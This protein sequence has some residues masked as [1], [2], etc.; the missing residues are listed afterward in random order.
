V[1]KRRA[2]ALAREI[3]LTSGS[4]VSAQ[5]EQFRPDGLW[6]VTV[7]VGDLVKR[8]YGPFFG[9]WAARRAGQHATLSDGWGFHVPTMY[10]GT[11]LRRCDDGS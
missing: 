8:V 2:V 4:K 1:Q 3:E 9:R 10:Q 6:G 5:A 7:R 11:D